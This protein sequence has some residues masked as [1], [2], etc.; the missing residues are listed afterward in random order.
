M[1]KFGVQVMLT[2]RVVSF[3]FSGR[4][5]LPRGGR[6][7]YVIHLHCI[8]GGC[9]YSLVNP[10]SPILMGN[11]GMLARALEGRIV[12]MRRTDLRDV[13]NLVPHDRIDHL[14]P[15]PRDGLQRLAAPRAASEGRRPRPVEGGHEPQLGGV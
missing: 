7:F 14:R 1:I 2:V 10:N 8:L 11:R 6:V 9:S 12:L 15:L 4:V 3:S 13:R 5:R